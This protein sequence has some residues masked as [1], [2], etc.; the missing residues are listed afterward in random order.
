MGAEAYR[1]A[2]Q[3]SSTARRNPLTGIR[4]TQ[5]QI[6]YASLL[7]PFALYRG[8]NQLGKTTVM[9]WDMIHT[10]RG[11]HPYRQPFRPPVNVIFMGESWEQMGR[12]G[13][14]MEK[15]W[16]LLPK[17]EIDPRNR[18]DPGRGITGKPPRIVF[19]DGPGKGSV[20]G[21]ATY[22]QGAKPQAGSTLHGCY[23]DEPPTPEIL[24][25]MVPRLFRHGGQMRVGFTPVVGMPDQRHLRQLV[26]AGS[27]VEL[28]PWLVE[29]NCWPVG[30]AKP[31]QTQAAIDRMAS[32][33]PE[34]IRAMRIEGSWDPILDTAWLAN[35]VRKKH[36][37]PVRMPPM[38]RLIVGVDHGIQAG[39]QTAVLVCCYG[40]SGLTPY[41][42]VVD[43][44][45]GDVTTT[46]R[47]D[48]QSI[49]DMLERNGL[50]WRDVDEWVG[51][52][53]AESKYMI[54]RKSNTILERYLAQ[55][56]GIARFPRFVVPVKGS[57][58]VEHGLYLMNAL[59]GTYDDQGI[60]H[61]IISARCERFAKF[62]E[63]FCGDRHD[64]LKDIGDAGR[65]AIER[66]M[67]G[68]PTQR[69]TALYS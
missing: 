3:A 61:M 16:Q 8:G 60:P 12:V 38:A 23:L 45:V 56:A 37:L 32:L 59:L 22:R 31:W 41:V 30:A 15:L 67:R 17:D 4:L 48:A 26:E 19:T 33:L 57:G 47:Q 35:F 28:N 55:L 64:P 18:L 11:T 6:D 25:E 40:L 49:V 42:Q 29:K 36:I 44:A 50:S 27:F 63:L 21:F 34:P 65:Y 7:D 68:A 14:P 58:S 43:E 2:R 62:C 54:K 51:D 13:G 69:I 66:A 20:I 24:Q 53:A 46:P 5:A 10:C 52:R 9:L 39:K 1:L